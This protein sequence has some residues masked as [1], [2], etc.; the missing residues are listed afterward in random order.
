[1]R[2]SH[3]VIGYEKAYDN[4]TLTGYEYNKGVRKLK[5]RIIASLFLVAVLMVAAVFTGCDKA[6]GG[7]SFTA[8]PGSVATVQG[9]LVNAQGDFC[10]FGFNAQPVKPQSITPE[11]GILSKGT[12]QFIDHKYQ[13]K[14]KGDFSVT[15][16]GSGSNFSDFAG[17]CT[18]NGQGTYVFGA[19]FTDNGPG[20]QDNVVIAVLNFTSFTDA[21]A[22]GVDLSNYMDYAIYAYSGLLDIGSDIVVHTT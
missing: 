4:T 3:I 15:V 20:Y 6:T 9:E 10:T 7:G 13:I 22:A 5:R 8:D 1:V 18:I 21:I 2:I 19:S 12:F 11:G 17:L 14:I 16:N